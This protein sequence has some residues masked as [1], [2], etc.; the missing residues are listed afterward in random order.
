M[1]SPV[2][3]PLSEEPDPELVRLAVRVQAEYAER[4]RTLTDPGTA[5]AY[6]IALDVMR[7]IH[8]GALATGVLDEEQHAVLAGMVDGA[9][10]APS[11][12]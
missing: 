7:M 10:R 9:D 5:E 3:L 11:V 8:A 6:R 12:L 4:G 2:P 1:P